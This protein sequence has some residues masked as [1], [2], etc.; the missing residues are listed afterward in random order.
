MVYLTGVYG[1]EQSEEGGA[2]NCKGTSGVH[3]LSTLPGFRAR[4]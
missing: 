4:L 2:T 1:Q 3:V